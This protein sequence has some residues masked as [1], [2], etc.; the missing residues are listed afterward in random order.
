ME[1]RAVMGRVLGLLGTICVVISGLSGA[2]S[3]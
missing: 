1:L 2:P 3:K